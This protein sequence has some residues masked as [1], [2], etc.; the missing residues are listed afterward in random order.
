MKD[1]LETVA[2]DLDSVAVNLNRIA[3]SLERLVVVTETVS[4]PL[5]AII[6]F[7]RVGN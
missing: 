1:S 7:A 4:A 6:N 2:Y 5:R 3:A